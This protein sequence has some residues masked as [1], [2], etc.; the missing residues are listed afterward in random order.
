M[1]HFIPETEMVEFYYV[2]KKMI[3]WQP[4]TVLT[5]WFATRNGESIKRVV[6][7]FVLIISLN[8]NRK[9]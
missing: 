7:R 1:Q 5:D 3:W 4:F 2:A 9:C 6:L 8:W